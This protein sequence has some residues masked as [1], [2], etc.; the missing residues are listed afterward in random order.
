MGGGQVVQETFHEWKTF[1]LLVTHSVIDRLCK[2]STQAQMFALMRK[3]FLDQWEHCWDPTKFGDSPDTALSYSTLHTSPEHT[4]TY[5]P[6]TQILLSTLKFPIHTH[7]IPA[8]LVPNSFVLDVSSASDRRWLAKTPTH[9]NQVNQINNG[10]N[11]VQKI[12]S[13][14]V[15]SVS[16]NWYPWKLFWKKQT[17]WLLRSRIAMSVA[18]YQGHGQISTNNQT[19]L[20]KVMINLLPIHIYS[21]QMI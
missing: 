11:N 1:K 14:F 8:T 5:K 18:G 12:I 4:H 16:T 20:R 6:H 19:R 2:Y 9:K 21:I 10:L 7:L 17:L 3:T 15:N 13:L